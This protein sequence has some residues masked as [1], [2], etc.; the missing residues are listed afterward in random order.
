MKTSRNLSKYAQHIL[1]KRYFCHPVENTMNLLHLAAKGKLINT[2]E[3]FCIY[4][5]SRKGVQVN[6]AYSV[7]TNSICDTLMKDQD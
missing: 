6:E 2:L 4:K 7:H 3:K 1:D 5:I